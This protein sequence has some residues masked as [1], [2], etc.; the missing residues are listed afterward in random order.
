[1]N[2]TVR[3]ALLVHK[4]NI[5]T[6]CND[7]Y[8][9]ERFHADFEARLKNYLRLLEETKNSYSFGW[10]GSDKGIDM[11]EQR[12]LHKMITVQNKKDSGGMIHLAEAHDD[13]IQSMVMSSDNN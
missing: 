3:K 4:F 13:S 12:V 2:E 5:D 1:M 6:E 7:Q 11:E 9:S 8:N 10:G